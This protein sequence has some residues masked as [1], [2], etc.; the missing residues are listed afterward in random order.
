MSSPL[1]LHVLPVDLARGAQTYARELRDAL[2]GSE[3]RHRTVTLF[4][5][6]GAALRPD[7]SLGVA[8][9][10]LR[11]LGLDPRVR[12]RLRGLLHAE[13]PAV[14]VAHGSE[15]LKY[16]AAAGVEAARLAYYKIGIG[17]DRL[18]GVSGHLHRRLLGRVGVVATVSDDAAEELFALGVPRD[19]ITVVP[20]GR[21]PSVYRPRAEG[22]TATASDRNGVV[23]LAF[24]GH[25]SPSK[26]PERFVD[27][28]GRLR[29]EGRSVDAV[30]AGDGPLLIP[31]RASAPDGIEVLGRVD[32]VPAVLA[33]AD[34]FVF[35]SVPEG[36]GMP[37]VLIEASLAGLPVV[38][39]AVPGA[40]AV[41]VDGETGFV[42]PV[43][44]FDALA[45]ATAA[46]VDD[47]A[48]RTQ[49]GAAGR[50]RATD[51]FGLATSVAA[52]RDLLAAMMAGRCASST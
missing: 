7:W 50:A 22:D 4:R 48:R 17:G 33:A 6:D 11:R 49:L 31:L 18:S 43:D 13:R 35:T 36:E 9:G 32:D 27:L 12:H 14:V 52:W 38:T 20:N 41:V 44:D 28:V 25:L 46:L 21:D 29:A 51:R 24:V 40:A 42:V 47:P 8:D 10:P 34:V 3:V 45:A 2:D 16:A 30:I 5:S 26:R 23:R 19:R 39:T 15:P 1:V 37:G